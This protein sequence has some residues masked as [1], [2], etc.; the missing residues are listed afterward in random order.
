[1]N[2]L[3]K[4]NGWL[5]HKDMS[6]ATIVNGRITEIID[7]VHLP[8]YLK[9]YTDLES[10]LK[11]RE[12]DPHRTNSRLLKK[13]LRLARGTDTDAVLHVNALALTDSFWIKQEDFDLTWEKVQLR[14]N[15]LADIALQGH[16]YTERLNTY[17]PDF[18]NIGSYEK[19]WRIEDGTWYMY[20]KG[21]AREVFSESLVY[22]VGKLLGF[23]MAE[24][25]YVGD[26]FIKSKN[27]TNVDLYDYEPANLWML[28]NDDYTGNYRYLQNISQELANQYFEI[29]LMGYA[30]LQCRSSYLP[31]RCF[32]EFRIR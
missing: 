24:Y 23:N 18:T 17:S 6:V 25:S 30:L 16:F 22:E 5:M 4:V 13:Y 10:W 7:K 8:I 19:C 29:L 32:E 26:N 21:T 27:F 20:K 15:E 9:N 31:L 3:E 12:I 28:E 1:M 2:A 11:T 14:Y